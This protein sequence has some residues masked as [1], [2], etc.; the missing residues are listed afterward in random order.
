MAEAAQPVPFTRA[1]S[2]SAEA[3][4]HQKCLYAG[5]PFPCGSRPMLVLIRG[6]IAQLLL[7][8]TSFPTSQQMVLAVRL[9]IPRAPPR[10]HFWNCCDFIE[11]LVRIEAN[12][13]SQI[14]EFDHVHASASRLNSRDY[15]LISINSFGQISL[16]QPCCFTLV[17]NQ[18]N[19][20]QMPW[21]PKCFLH[22]LPVLDEA[23]RSIK[24]KFG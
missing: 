5:A 22:S 14:E 12:R 11:D 15:R 2:E 3:K 19:K 17:H 23:G 21:R 13:F 20:A 4:V 10:S 8:A 6:G 7:P 1:G 18:L 9:A 24:W 16:A